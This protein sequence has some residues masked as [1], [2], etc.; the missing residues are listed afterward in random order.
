V[1]RLSAAPHEA[2]RM[3]SRLHDAHRAVA[4]GAGLRTRASFHDGVGCQAARGTTWREVRAGGQFRHVGR[5]DATSGCWIRGRV[6]RAGRQDHHL[7]GEPADRRKVP[8]RV[9]ERQMRL[10]HRRN[11]RQVHDQGRHAVIRNA[12]TPLRRRA[13]APRCRQVWRVRRD[14]HRK[15]GQDRDPVRRD[16][17]LLGRR[18]RHAESLGAYQGQHASTQSVVARRPQY[19]SSV[20]T[21][22]LAQTNPRNVG[23]NAATTIPRTFLSKS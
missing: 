11:D 21:G 22:V 7:Q 5:G 8:H 15:P 3:R 12:A 23:T 4:G 17:V 20:S 1:E 13:P 9:H 2:G 10:G 6:G 19:V 16:H 14:G 18:H